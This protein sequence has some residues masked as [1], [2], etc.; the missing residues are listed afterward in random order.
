MSAPA[1]SS[2]VSPVSEKEGSPSSV[3]ESSRPLPPAAGIMT[4]RFARS[5]EAQG[6]ARASVRPLRVHCHAYDKEMIHAFP[7]SP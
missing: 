2:Q 7:S 1:D 4:D 5:A 3:I 6:A